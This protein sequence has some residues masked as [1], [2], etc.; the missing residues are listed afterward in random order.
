[1]GDQ[2]AILEDKARELRT[3]APTAPLKEQ[4]NIYME[5]HRIEEILMR[6]D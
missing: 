4:I 5:L 1:M 3:N 2:V 6:M